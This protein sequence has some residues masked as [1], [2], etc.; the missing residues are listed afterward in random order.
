[1]GEVRHKKER[2]PGQHEAIIS[3]ELWEQVQQRLLSGAA[4]S[5]EGRKTEAPQ[6]PL[7][8]KRFDESGEPIYVQ[9]SAKGQRRYRY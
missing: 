7:A 5:S 9:G 6:S 1:V 2:Y 3:R 8:G 4:R